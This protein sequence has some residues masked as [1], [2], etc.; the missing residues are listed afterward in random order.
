MCTHFL[1]THVDKGVFRVSLVA[2][3][4]GSTTFSLFASSVG[5]F[6]V[7]SF[8]RLYLGIGLPSIRLDVA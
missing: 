1:G 7:T 8:M 3:A 2:S 4:L 6:F 5:G